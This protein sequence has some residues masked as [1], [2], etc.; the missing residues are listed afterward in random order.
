MQT[1][2]HMV[3]AEIPQEDTV[4]VLGQGGH[5]GE[6]G[7]GGWRRV[8]ECRQGATCVGGRVSVEEGHP[9]MVGSSRP[10]RLV[11]SGE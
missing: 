3:C 11:R 10:S 1:W 4:L 7:G 2:G 9:W 8:E 5:G 6:E